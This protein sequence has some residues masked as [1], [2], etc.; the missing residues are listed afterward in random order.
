MRKIDV[1]NYASF[2]FE[3]DAFKL[4]GTFKTCKQQFTDWS[5]RAVLYGIK[6]DG[7]KAIIDSKN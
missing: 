1:K 7:T 4:V 2:Q 3:C 6:K 5:G